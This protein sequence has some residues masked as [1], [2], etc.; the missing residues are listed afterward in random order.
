MDKAT[1][2]KLIA[3]EKDKARVGLKHAI[4]LLGKAKA[5]GHQP[6]IDDAQKVVNAAMGTWDKVMFLQR[7]RDDWYAA[8][9]SGDPKALVDVHA[10]L[11]NRPR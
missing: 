11:K 3:V 2:Y 5:T 7:N 6:L 10:A 1:T 9:E 8:V 4:Q